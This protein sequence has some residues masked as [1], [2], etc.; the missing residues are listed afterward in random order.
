MA[1]TTGGKYRP[2]SPHL[3]IYRWSGAMA[4][5]IVHRITG[6]ALFVGMGLLAWWLVAA[7]SGPEAFATVNRFLSSTPGKVI[8]AGFTWALIHHTAG[9]IRHLVLDAGAGMQRR[10]RNLLA[11]GTLGASV[12]LTIIVWM[13]AH[14]AQ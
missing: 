9:G 8:L 10:S 3:Q 14:Y 11:W 13:L 5:S 6:A 12:L 7:A 1:E 4:M 2:L